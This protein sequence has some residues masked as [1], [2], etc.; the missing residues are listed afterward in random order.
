MCDL[1][2]TV[3]TG[4]VFCILYVAV[5]TTAVRPVCGISTGISITV[6]FKVGIIELDKKHPTA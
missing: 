2:T 3:V 4:M 5:Y 1:L 6:H